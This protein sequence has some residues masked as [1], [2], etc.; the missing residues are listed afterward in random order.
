MTSPGLTGR[1]QLTPA[2]VRSRLEIATDVRGPAVARVLETLPYGARPPGLPR[3]GWLRLD[4][5]GL[6]GFRF[7][8]VVQRSPWPIVG[9]VEPDEGGSRVVVSVPVVTPETFVRA[10]LGLAILAL[11]G[12]SAWE[13]G[14]LIAVGMTVGTTVLLVV[15]ELLG[16]HGALQYARR[17]A[18][19]ATA[20]EQAE[21]GK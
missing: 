21:G 20:S 5:L 9:Q 10:I 17:I 11:F 1:S 4:H 18:R 14:S 13:T 6:D 19:V 12:V 15:V 3:F 2:E 7:S 16:W 8:Y